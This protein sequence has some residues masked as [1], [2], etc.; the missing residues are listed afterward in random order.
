MANNI[1]VNK[2]DFFRYVEAGIVP[3]SVN[4]TKKQ[5]KNGIYK[6]QIDWNGTWSTSTLKNPRFNASLN[7][8]GLQT[9]KVSGIF[10]LDI[11]D[12]DYWLKLL[13]DED[14]NEPITATVISGSGGIHYYFK[15][16]DNLDVIPNTTAV[17]GDKID[18]RTN[19]GCIFAP[20]S[21]YYNEE[22]KT[23]SSYVWKN[24]KSIF[25]YGTNLPTMPKWLFN[26]IVNNLEK[27]NNV[28]KKCDN[29]VK[30]EKKEKII[31]DVKPTDLIKINL[32]KQIVALD[33][34]QLNEIIN[35][36]SVERASDY[37]QWI[38]VMFCLKSASNVDNFKYFD[39]FSK[40]S[41]DY[42]QLSVINFWNKKSSKTGLLTYNTLLYYC[43]VDSPVMYDDF[44]KK[45]LIKE[46]CDENDIIIDNNVTVNRP[47]LLNNKVL[48]KNCV[49]S[50]EI[51]K[52]LDDDTK[53]LFIKSP[54]DTGKTTF[55]KTITPKFEKIL[56][57]SYR[58]TLSE[59]LLGSFPD[60]E[61]YYDSFLENKIICQVDSLS[62]ISHNHY[63]LII[64]DECESVLNHFSAGSLKNQKDTFELF[65]FF[66]QSAK[67]IIC[68]DGDLGNRSKRIFSSFGSQRMIT[69]EIKK[70]P[71]HFIFTPN[72]ELFK[73]DIDDA[74]KA[75]K[76]IV[77]VSMSDNLAKE[78]YNKYKKTHKCI[79]YTSSTS[80]ENKKLLAQVEEI[81]KEYQIIIYSPSIESGVDFNVEDYIDNIYVVLCTR[82]TSQR[83]LNQMIKRCRKINN[84]NILVYTNNLSLQDKSTLNYY[85]YNINEIIA[86]YSSLLGEKISFELLPDG[87]ITRN[88]CVYY[89]LYD[90]LTIYN[91]QEEINKNNNCFIPY[92]IK[93]ISDK[94]HTYEILRTRGIKE[95]KGDNITHTIIKD[96]ESITCD[97]YEELIKKQVLR[98]LTED[99]KMQ[100]KKYIY[101]K[102]FGVKF[103]DAETI[104]KYYGRLNIMSN[105]YKLFN[106]ETRFHNSV[107]VGKEKDEKIKVVKDILKMFN[108]SNIKDKEHILTSEDLKQNIE[109]FNQLLQNNKI[110]LGL[111]KSI[112]IEKTNGVLG[113]LNTILNS[114]GIDIVTK[115]GKNKERKKIY[116]YIIKLDENVKE[117]V[118][119]SLFNNIMKNFNS[120][121]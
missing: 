103:D 53:I 95:P 90:I 62:R 20:P 71:N 8:L 24:G 69:N 38:K 81:W 3:F 27:K 67:K 52:F 40:K 113:S 54:Y 6:K 118:N 117:K 30:K 63:D 92:F 120:L 10:V 18:A 102:T 97:E 29:D 31:K 15:Y 119:D 106:D 86:Y 109:P 94:G 72:E 12:V 93:M 46:V 13:E 4:I 48:E 23:V 100:I 80:D 87:E 115:E 96:S 11:D 65:C 110:L 82:S 39:L 111:S 89:N 64:I 83:G 70:D 116:N 56:F 34:I 19:G 44:K 60:F 74:I 79:I 66:L 35:M 77:I 84:K 36:L 1:A 61:I 99:E 76:N 9:G 47:Y 49:V 42:D 108:L 105:A 28:T 2:N 51:N 43:K 22:T 25:D 98:I 85:Y 88:E 16:E 5:N 21:S 101:E 57:I 41:L 58:I 112:K 91:K 107:M 59:N 104:K 33:D 73:T 50:N 68:L 55:L 37:D 17:I 7:A 78:F 121:F 14:R 45:Y 32:E 26:M 114:Y 75:K